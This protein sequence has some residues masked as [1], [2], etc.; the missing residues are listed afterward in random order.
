ME[1]DFGLYKVDH[2]YTDIHSRFTKSLDTEHN[3]ISLALL[4][5]RNHQVKFHSVDV[6]IYS[7]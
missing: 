4:K 7:G 3:T 2:N 5:N 1:R 6:I